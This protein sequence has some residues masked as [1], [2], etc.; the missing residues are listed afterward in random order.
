M[1]GGRLTMRAAV[2]RDQAVAT[3]AWGGKVAPDFQ[4]IGDPL[5]CFVYSKSGREVVDGDKTAVIEDLRVMFARGADVQ[6]DD[7]IAQVTD[8]RGNVLIAGR[9]K[10]DGPVQF[11]HN[12]VEAALERVG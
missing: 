12:H 7:E 1:I 11:K 9:L 2:E 8:A 4:S 6:P 3:D 5:P 10:V